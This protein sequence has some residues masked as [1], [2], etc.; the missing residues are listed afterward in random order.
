MNGAE[1]P[2]GAILQV[3]PADSNYEQKQNNPCAHGPQTTSTLH[4][5]VEASQDVKEGDA[6]DDDSTGD[7]EDFFE[8]LT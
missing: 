4:G 8:S 3:Q 2:C 6:K 7:L 5:K 1:L